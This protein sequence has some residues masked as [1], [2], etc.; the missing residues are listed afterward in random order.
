MNV[1]VVGLVSGNHFIED[2]RVEVPYRMAVPI[3]AE[4]VVR[5][6]DLQRAI[7]EKK[8]LKVEGALPQ[9]VVMRPGGAIPRSGAVRPQPSRKPPQKS[10]DSSV[11]TDNARLA[12]ELEESKQREQSLLRQIEGLQTLNQGMQT[13]MTAMSGQLTVIQGVLEDLKKQGIQV[14]AVPGV[15]APGSSEIDGSAPMFVT[16]FNTDDA[17]VNINVQDGEKRS[18]ASLSGAKAALKNLRKKSS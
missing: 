13:T 16:K 3:P 5:S 17:K 10:E 8:L 18:S 6:R 15:T 11:R 14:T 7:Q 9:G 4:A 1:V 2:I 12:R